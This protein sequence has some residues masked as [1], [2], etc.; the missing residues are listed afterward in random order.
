MEKKIK[1]LEMEEQRIQ[2]MAQAQ[3]KKMG[4]VLP[5][6]EIPNTSSLMS[7]LKQIFTAMERFTA[8]SL[9]AYEELCVHIQEEER[10]V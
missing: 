6:T 9:Q 1:V 8:N 10:H 7:G 4:P 2:K 3:E 5:R